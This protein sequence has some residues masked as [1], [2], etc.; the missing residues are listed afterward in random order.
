MSTDLKAIMDRDERRRRM[1]NDPDLTGDLLLLTLALDE[2]LVSRNEQGRKKLRN[3]AW[4][5]AHLTHGN[6]DYHLR[7]W[8]KKVIADD[9][10]R[11]EPIKPKGRG[12]VA[13]MVRR[14]GA[15]GNA[16]TTSRVDR[17]PLTGDS[18]WVHYCA[19][20][21]HLAGPVEARIREWV[22]NGKPSPPANT[23]GVLRRYFDADWDTVYRWA[24][25]REP[26]EGGREATPPRPK[27]R[28]ITGGAEQL[29]GDS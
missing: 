22:E 19:R 6:S 18:R 1:L 3:W 28:L 2:F 29:G 25:G 24:S 26:M 17:D 13:P 12:C 15:C 10:P 16:G 14:E 11:Y 23:G 5:V 7:Y 21:K 27:L 8:T 20:H 4:E 9:L